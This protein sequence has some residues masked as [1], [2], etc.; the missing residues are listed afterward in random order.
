MACLD[1]FNR[2]ISYLRVSVT[3]RC[4][5]RCMYCM[6]PEGV[7]WVPHENILRYE[8]IVRVVRVGAEMGITKVRLTGGEPLVRAGIASLVA[9]I[10]AIP[11]V[12]DLAMTT[13]GTLLAQYADELAKAGLD[14]VNV[15]LDTLRPERFRAITR[16]G[17]LEDVERGLVAAR[18][19][20]LEPVKVNTVLMRGVNDDEVVDFARRTLEEP[21]HVRFIEEMPVGVAAATRFLPVAEARERIEAAFGPLEAAHHRMGNGPASYYRIPGAS[22]TIGF[23]SAVSEHF[24]HQCNRLRLTADGRLRPCLLS[25]AEIPLREALRSG[26]SDEELKQIILAAV[27]AKPDGHHLGEGGAVSGRGMSQIGG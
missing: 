27:A 15:S 9:M 17:S 23:I 8:E 14:R 20:G 1:S 5:L 26:V 18:A 13:N 2:S 4:N 22:G 25:D 3:D 7:P 6:P 24:C 21:F 10:A 19:A 11:G 16:L 12:D